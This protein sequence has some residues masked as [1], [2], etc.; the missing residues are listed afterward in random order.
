MLAVEVSGYM[1]CNFDESFSAVCRYHGF[2]WTRI[3]IQ[4]A[5]LDKSDWIALRAFIASFASP[6]DLIIMSLWTVS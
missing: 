4:L 5:S 6:S 1:V 2:V 3:D